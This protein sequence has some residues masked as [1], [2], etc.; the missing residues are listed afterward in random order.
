MSQLALASAAS[1]LPTLIAAAGDQAARRFL[2]F[3]AATI[4]SPHT[5][6]AYGRAVAEFLAWCDVQGVPSVAAV[7]PL[8]VLR[9]LRQHLL[10]K[11]KVKPLCS[12]HCI[13]AGKC[14]C[15]AS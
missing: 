11:H 3:F 5:R 9:P 6:R 14:I 7:Q 13:R 10:L 8:H 2:E 1:N 12:L 15:T 4:R